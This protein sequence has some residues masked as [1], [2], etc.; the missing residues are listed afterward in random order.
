MNL[1]APSPSRMI[2]WARSTHTSRT[3][4]EKLPYSSPVAEMVAPL[5]PVA[6][7]TQESLVEVSP[8]TVMALKESVM[9]S[10][11]TCRNSAS[12][13]AASVAI[14]ASIVAISGRIMP[15]PLAMP[16][17]VTSRPATVS[18]RD[19]HL[20][21]VSVVMIPCAASSQPSACNAASAAGNPATSRNSGNGS[22]MTPVEKG[23]T[24]SGVQ[25]VSSARVWQLAS[26]SANPC[27]P[28]PAL[29]LPVLISR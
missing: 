20:G 6:N 17:I 3:A 21:R 23:S 5:W 24:S 16:V 8:S 4:A 27:R 7:R 1:V 22:P 15:A 10:V 9:A 19:A 25:A 29:A 11:S 28:V 26:A 12:S 13:T 18:R 14:N 2:A